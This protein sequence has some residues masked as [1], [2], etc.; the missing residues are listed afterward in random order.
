[1]PASPRSAV[2]VTDCRSVG[3]VGACCAGVCDD[4]AITELSSIE[5]AIG[6]SMEIYTRFAAT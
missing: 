5:S 6:R 2:T 1:M 4:A 3:G